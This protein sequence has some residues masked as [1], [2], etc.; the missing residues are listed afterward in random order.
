MYVCFLCRV[1][2]SIETK[3]FKSTVVRNAFVGLLVGW[4]HC[5]ECECD[6]KTVYKYNSVMRFLASL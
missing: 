3:G 4:T 1:K 6:V 5:T 2:Q